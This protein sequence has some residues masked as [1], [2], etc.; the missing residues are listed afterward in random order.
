MPSWLRVALLKV[1]VEN[2]CGADTPGYLMPRD[3][4]L[5]HLPRTRVMGAHSMLGGCA[6]ALLHRHFRCSHVRRLLLLL[7]CLRSGRCAWFE[8]A[9]HP[10]LRSAVLNSQHR[11]TSGAMHH[12]GLSAARTRFWARWRGSFTPWRGCGAGSVQESVRLWCSPSA[13]AFARSQSL[14][15]S[16][17]LGLNLEQSVEHRIHNPSVVHVRW[18]PSTKFDPHRRHTVFA[19]FNV[20][21]FAPRAPQ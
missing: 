7:S 1:T 16:V 8:K 21:V 13:F 17:G 4:V 6:T 20:G 10:L 14:L 2:N 19:S 18:S 5:R 11:V 15:S 9:A 12:G 3:A